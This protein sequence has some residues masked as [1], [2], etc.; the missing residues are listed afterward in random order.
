MAVED[1]IINNSYDSVD[2]GTGS[3]SQQAIS[4]SPLVE[5]MYAESTT[6]RID[7]LYSNKKLMEEL[8][9]LYEESEYYN[10]YKKSTKKIERPDVF[11][12]YHYFKK[13]LEEKSEYTAV[14]I[15]CA[16]AEFFDLNYKVLYNDIITLNDKVEILD[17]LQN[18]YGLEKEFIKSRRLF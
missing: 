8:H 2:Y 13:K 9:D 4:I 10:K 15:F 12:M 7:E 5:D 17:V 1:K 6:E 11:D 3:M 16:I 18:Q 14:Q